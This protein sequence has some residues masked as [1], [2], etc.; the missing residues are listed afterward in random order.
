MKAMPKNT[1]AKVFV[2]ATLAFAAFSPVAFADSISV[3]T[4]DASAVGENSAVLNGYVST[5]PAGSRV[6]VYFEWSGGPSTSPEDYNGNASFHATV[7]G[8]LPGR[9]YS[10]RAVAI[11][12]ATGMTASGNT[13][14]FTTGQKQYPSQ[15]SPTVDTSSA[16]NVTSFSAVLNGSVNPQGSA[17]TVRWFDW[18]TTAAF[19]NSTPKA[20]QG[21]SA[22]SFSYSISNLSPNTTYYYRAVAQNSYGLV[23]GTTFSFQ[24]S[25]P[26]YLSTPPT[27]TAGSTT[28]F[29]ITQAPRVVADTAA[30]VAGTAFPGGTVATRGWF[31]WGTNASLGNQ[32]T[33]QDIGSA[34]AIDFSEN[35]PNLSVNTVYYYRAV[36]ENSKGRANGIILSFVTH[37]VSANGSGGA[38]KKQPVISKPTTTEPTP[39]STAA[40][41]TIAAC[42]PNSLSGWLLILLLVVLIVIAIDHLVDRY[43]KRKEERERR[44]EDLNKGINGPRVI[45]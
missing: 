32:T 21:T 34:A 39:T 29:V 28:P 40:I 33:P 14:T 5:D 19:G 11:S 16:S 20:N 6:T 41:G 27:T 23:N 42:F 1:I 9:S 3:T 15:Q 8:L 10:F 24:T 30:V 2:A 18:G 13:L 17:D 22:G 12:Q 36:I 37:P 45:K 4:Y 25:G 35:I 26:N 38:T 7:S 31:E 44:G 43:R